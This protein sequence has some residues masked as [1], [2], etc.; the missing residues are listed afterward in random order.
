LILFITTISSAEIRTRLRL[1]GT[2][3]VTG[4][5][6]TN[7]TLVTSF[8]QTITRVSN[9]TATAMPIT[10]NIGINLGYGQIAVIAP[11]LAE[12]TRS[13]FYGGANGGVL[14]VANGSLQNTTAYDGFTMF[15]SANN[16][17]GNIRV[18]G[19]DNS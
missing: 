2:D 4:Y 11:Q 8:T 17:T 15:A 5:S 3:A 10:E 9:G 7:A 18:Y 19:Y 16:M 1:S 14:C 12:N 6:H 13:T